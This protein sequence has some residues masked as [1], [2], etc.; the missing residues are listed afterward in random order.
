MAD[1]GTHGEVTGMVHRALAATTAIVGIFFM[2][3][4]FG[5]VVD[6]IREKMDE[7]KKVRTVQLLHQLSN[8]TARR[9]RQNKI[10]PLHYEKRK[11]PPRSRRPARAR[12]QL[13]SVAT[14]C[15]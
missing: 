13:S 11:W 8:D 5:I 6:T 1:P 15:C 12:P 14:R 4:I 9:I 7:L 2:S 3:V 10:S